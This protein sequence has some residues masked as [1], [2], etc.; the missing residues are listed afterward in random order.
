MNIEELVV[1]CQKVWIEMPRQVRTIRR[2]R[3]IRFTLRF[4]HAAPS[5]RLKT[6]DS[7]VTYNI[8]P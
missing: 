8:T 7:R 1:S 4:F 6:Q 3:V 5:S 2:L